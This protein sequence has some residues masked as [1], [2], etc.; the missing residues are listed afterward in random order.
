[1][2]TDV[3]LFHGRQAKS[4]EGSLRYDRVN[5]ATDSQRG[6]WMPSGRRGKIKKKL[7]AGCLA[8]TAAICC[9]R[10]CNDSDGP[11]VEDEK[12]IAKENFISNEGL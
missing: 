1:M 3:D 9:C 11:E 8:A 4:M 6:S 12:A 2:L 7:V 10:S 5:K